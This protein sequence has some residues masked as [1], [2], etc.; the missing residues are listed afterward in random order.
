MEGVG[1][2]GTGVVGSG[3]RL[4][5]ESCSVVGLGDY[6]MPGDLFLHCGDWEGRMIIPVNADQG[7]NGSMLL[8]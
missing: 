5:H 2:A 7:K 1:D 6:E 3:A 4:S 8:F